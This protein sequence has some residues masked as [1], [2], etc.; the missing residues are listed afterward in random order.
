[1]IGSTILNTSLIKMGVERTVSFV[2]TLVVFA[3][4]NYSI[5][6]FMNDRVVKRA[7]SK[8]MGKADKKKNETKKKTP[9][10]KPVRKPPVR[11]RGGAIAFRGGAAAF[12]L[13]DFVV[14]TGTPVELSI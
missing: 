10:R 3:C 6:K 4:L 9:A 8:A 2:T 7:D 5:L 13:H 11:A 12:G 1:M 14:S